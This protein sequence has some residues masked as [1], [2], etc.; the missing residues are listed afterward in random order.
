MLRSSQLI[1]TTKT[2][3]PDGARVMKGDRKT[4]DIQA[5]LSMNL[6]RNTVSKDLDETPSTIEMAN[7]VGLS[8]IISALLGSDDMNTLT[9]IHVRRGIFQSRVAANFTS[10]EHQLECA[11]SADNVVAVTRLLDENKKRHSKCFPLHMA[12]L[13]GSSDTT[14]ELL[15]ILGNIG[16]INYEGRTMLHMAAV[17]GSTDII[18]II[19][20]EV[21]TTEIIN[22]MYKKDNNAE[23]PLLL[24]TRFGNVAAV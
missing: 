20:K 15:G 21:K 4:T 18:E 7:L 22:A 9:T 11:I 2:N 13:A 10:L 19:R 23:T 17:S 3:S 16:D 24:A 5:D 14:R 12:T 6:T 1:L 8:T